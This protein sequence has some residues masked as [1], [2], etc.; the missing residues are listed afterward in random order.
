MSY[1]SLLIYIAILQFLSSLWIKSRLEKSIEHEY[2]R[3]LEDYKFSLRRKAEAAKIAELFAK[4]IKYGGNERTLIS[5][6]EQQRNYYEELN[7]LSYELTL[8]VED[9][10]LIKKIAR[11]LQRQDGH[12]TIEK[13]IVQIRKLILDKNGEDIT[14][15]DVTHWPKDFQDFHAN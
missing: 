2:S 3:K 14:E 6:K 5:D 11:L 7:R 13:I 15:E 8:W 12:V 1:W 10:V 9:Q 4:W